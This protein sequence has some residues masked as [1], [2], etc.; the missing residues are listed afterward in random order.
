MNQCC[1][2][3]G[4]NEYPRVATCPVNGRPYR[5]VSRR[6]LLH[7]VK[8]PWQA[9]LP[10]QGYYFCT[11]PG[12]DVVYFGADRHVIRR[13]GVRLDVGQKSTADDRTVCYCFDMSHADI[14][15]AQ[16]DTGNPCKNF[17]VE[18][19]RQSACDCESR[20]PSGRCCLKDF[21]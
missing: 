1:A 3:E 19:T 15:A 11:D 16:T 20:N 13:D 6:T 17:V 8:K 14:Q 21:P 2:G 12:C 18:L 9:T 7:H 10:E 5:Q 4:K